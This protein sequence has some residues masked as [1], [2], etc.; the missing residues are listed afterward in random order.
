M[1]PVVPGGVA[2]G[3]PPPLPE[4]RPRPRLC[5]LMQD[6]DLGH[7]SLNETNLVATC[8]PHS[9]DR[10]AGW[11]AGRPADPVR[12]GRQLRTEIPPTLAPRRYG[13]R[14]VAAFCC[15]ALRHDWHKADLLR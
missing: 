5:C 11:P 7:V 9:Q 15:G 10:G 4:L 2:K 14:T 1:P 13:D 12:V 8:W 3:R 6:C